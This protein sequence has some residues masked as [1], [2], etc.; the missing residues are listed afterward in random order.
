MNEHEKTI[1][2]V[3]DIIIEMV[4]SDKFDNYTLE[5]LAQRIV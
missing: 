3:L 1:A 2:Y 4:K 5:E